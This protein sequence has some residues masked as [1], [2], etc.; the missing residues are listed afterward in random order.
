MQPVTRHLSLALALLL[1]FLTAALTAQI[2]LERETRRLQTDAIAAKR[3]QFLKALEVMA[4]PP[5]IWGEDFQHDLG[6]VLGATVSIRR[7]T[8]PLSPPGPEAGLLSFEHVFPGEPGFYAHVAFAAPASNRLVALHQRTLVA[9]LLLALLLLLVSILLALARRSATD[10]GSHPPWLAARRE[11]HGLEQLARISVERGEA[12]ARESGAR[13]RAEEDL[14]L[15]RTLLGQSRD[16]R[17]RLGRELHDNICQTLYAVSLTL[18]GLRGK[19]AP[20]ATAVTE[21]R[22]DQCIAE[23]RRLNHEVRTYLKGLE[24]VTVQR[25][26]FVEALDSMLA[27]QTRPETTRLVR[28]IDEEATALIPPEQATEVVNLLRE[29]VSNSVKHSCGGTIT[30]HAQRGDGC[31]VL[32]VQDDG[33]GFDPAGAEGQGHGLANMQARAEALGGSVQV[34]SSVGKGTRV[35]LTLPVISAP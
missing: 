12:L 19:L 16:E 5:T 27:A 23:L 1:V 28:N 13:H 30:V 32:A 7:G 10:G 25:Q 20:G 21:Q 29:A 22:L 26:R 4:P 18:E 11:M 15:S 24:P 8:P 14:Q 31:I 34:L 9:V 6:A 33:T 17:V 3:A 35:L 2:W